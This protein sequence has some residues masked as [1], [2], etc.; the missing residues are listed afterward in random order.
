MQRR[1][2]RSSELRLVFSSVL[3]NISS[4]VNRAEIAAVVG[5][6]LLH[7]L[8]TT[9]DLHSVLP[10][11]AVKQKVNNDHIPGC[12]FLTSFTTCE[13]LA[14]FF[15]QVNVGFAKNGNLKLMGETHLIGQPG[16]S[17]FP[18]STSGTFV[19]ARG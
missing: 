10:D 16:F 17:F 7:A 18:S 9:S 1:N 3:P 19:G 5:V 4:V 12:F 6:V 11:S 14:M 2:D 13:F 15:A 8:T